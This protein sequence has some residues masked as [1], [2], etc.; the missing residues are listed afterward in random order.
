MT[1]NLDSAPEDVLFEVFLRCNVI[2]V[3]SLK[4]VR[5]HLS[6][7]EMSNVD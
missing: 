2:D 3:L 4:Q 5:P 1:G 6:D 7:V